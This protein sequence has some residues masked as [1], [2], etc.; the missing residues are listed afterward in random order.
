MDA[1]LLK[2]KRTIATLKLQELIRK[3]KCQ[4]CGEPHEVWYEEQPDQYSTLQADIAQIT[5]SLRERKAPVLEG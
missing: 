3:I 1:V 5:G 2:K 4:S